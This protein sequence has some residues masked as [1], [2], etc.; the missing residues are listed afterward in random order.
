M[1]DGGSEFYPDVFLAGAPKSGTTFLFNFLSS[2]D[3]ISSS[4]PKETNFYLDRDN[5]NR[6]PE[7]FLNKKSYLSYYENYG[8]KDYIHLDGSVWTIYQVGLIEKLGSLDEKPKVIFVL[9]EPARRIL[10]SFQYTSNNLS[11]VRGMSF[12]EYAECLVNSN[13]NDIAKACKDEKAAFSLINELK[14]SNYISYLNL[15]NKHLG[16]EKMLIL[17]FEEMIQNP[18]KALETTCDFLGIDFKQPEVNVERKNPTV[19]VR[20]K[21]I[22]YLLYKA[23]AMT[24]YRLPFK[25][26]V[27]KIYGKLQY[28]ASVK[29][30]KQEVQLE[31]LKDYYKP[32][33]EQLAS[34]FN[35]NLSSW[36]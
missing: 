12:Q 29:D 31:I 6:K 36:K 2:V 20:N 13:Y 7:R 18:E 11:A 15:W 9:R 21:S 32:F 8:K 23:F 4:S 16:K 5:P 27:K 24:G 30:P 14:Y 33:N 28:S 25:K 19:N 17:I 10:S 34:Q 22:H 35:L 1:I 26:Q 3:L